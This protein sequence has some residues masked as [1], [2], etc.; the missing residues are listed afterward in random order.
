MLEFANRNADLILDVHSGIYRENYLSNPSTLDLCLAIAEK[1]SY[2]QGYPVAASTTTVFT[3]K[4]ALA[5]EMKRFAHFTPLPQETSFTLQSSLD[6]GF[7]TLDLLAFMKL[8]ESEANP[9]GRVNQLVRDRIFDRSTAEQ[10]MPLCRPTFPRLIK[11]VDDEELI[12]LAEATW[13][14]DINSGHISPSEV[15]GIEMMSRLY[16]QTYPYAKSFRAEETR[17]LFGL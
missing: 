12:D 14:A 17:K 1:D 5:I 9:E 16:R 7:R 10:M 8:C 15:S 2:S 6:A 3:I 11:G 13:Q 4:N